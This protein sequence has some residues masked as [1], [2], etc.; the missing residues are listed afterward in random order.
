MKTYR[1]IFKKMSSMLLPAIAIRCFLFFTLFT[2]FS[3]IPSQAYSAGQWHI[4]TVDATSVSGGFGVS[5]ALDSSSRPHI[6]YMDHY[7]GGIKQNLRYA[8]WNGTSWDIQVVENCNIYSA[9]STS[10]VIDGLDNP[11]ISYVYAVDPV[12]CIF[13][14][15][16]ASWNGSWNIQTADPVLGSDIPYVSL[17][18][19]G[20]GNPCIAYVVRDGA[21]YLL[22]YAS[23]EE[24]SWNI[25]T[26]EATSYFTALSLDG[27]GNPHIAYMLWDGAKYLL[28][29]ASWEE[30]SWNIQT[31]EANLGNKGSYCSIKLDSSDNPHI[32]YVD[33]T[34]NTLKHASWNGTGWDIQLVAPSQG[35]STSLALDSNGH[36]YISYTYS[37]GDHLRCAAWNGT[38]WESQIV[39]TAESVGYYSSLAIDGNGNPHIAYSDFYNDALK[40]ASWEAEPLGG[41]LGGIKVTIEAPSL[42]G[43]TLDA[44]TKYIISWEATSDNGFPPGGDYISIYFSSNEG[45]SWSTITTLEENDPGTSSGTYEW[46]VPYL[47]FNNKCLISIEATDTSL[48]KAYDISDNTFKIKIMLLTVYVS[49]TGSD[50]TGTGTSWGTAFQTLQKGLNTVLPGG[51]VLLTGGTYTGPGNYNVLWP[52]YTGITLQGAGLG[53]TIISAEALGR[54][55]KVGNAVQ[56][57]IESLTIRD[58]EVSDG[59]G[60]AIYLSPG[61]SLWL[62]NVRMSGNKV[63]SIEGHAGVIS[64]VGSNVYALNS[65]FIRNQSGRA[66]SPEHQSVYAHGGVGHKG[67]WEVN[68]CQFIYNYAFGNGGVFETLTSLKATN[69]SFYGNFAALPYGDGSCLHDV[70]NAELTGCVFYGNRSNHGGVVYSSG[71]NLVTN[72]AFVNNFADNGGGVSLGGQWAVM[73]STFYEN[74]STTGPVAEGGN[75]DITNCIFWRNTSATYPDIYGTFNCT[76]TLKYCDVE[77]LDYII[78]PHFPPLHFP[79]NEGFSIKQDPLFLA[80]TAPYDIQLNNL[81]PCMNSGT[82][83]GA[84]PTDITGNSRPLPSINPDQNFDMGCYEQPS[85][86][87]INVLG[88]PAV[89]VLDPSD[90]GITLEA[91]SKYIITWT[92]T[93]DYL[94]FP[95]NDYISIYFSS[96]GGGTWTPVTALQEN[97]PAG[98][99]GTF[100][101][102]V[103]DLTSASCYISV[104]AKDI[105]GNIGSDISNNSFTIYQPARVIYPNGNE[106]FVIGSTNPVTWEIHGIPDGNVNIRLSRDGGS[107]WPEVIYSG[108]ALTGVS[109]YAWPTTGPASDECLISVEAKVSGVWYY[110]S[111][112]SVFK[113]IYPLAVT[114]EAPNGNE[115][116]YVGYPYNIQWKVTPEAE[117]IY[118]RLSTNEGTTWDTIITHETWTHTGVCTFSWI[119]TTDLVSTECLISVEASLNGV[120][121]NDRSNLTFSIAIP[122]FNVYINDTGSDE[123]GSGTHLNPYRTVTKGLV[124][125]DPG[126]VVWVMPGSYNEPLDYNV[127]WPNKNNVALKLT[128]EANGTTGPAT[129]DANYMGRIMTVPNAVNLT[130][131]GLTLQKGKPASG[132]NGGAINVTSYGATLLLK[133]D[134]IQYCTVES[135]CYGGAVY[136]P[137]DSTTIYASGTTFRNNNAYI[138]GVLYSGT[139]NAI[140]CAFISNGAAYGSVA[141][142][143]IWSDI[144]NCIFVSNNPFNKSFGSVAYGGTW[145]VYDSIFT[146]NNQGVANSSYFTVTN[147]T[148]ESNPGGVSN[149]GVW[150]VNNCSFIGNG[151][152]ASSPTW[153]VSD[154]IF[155]NN[156]KTS[157][158]GGVFSGVNTVIATNC[159]FYNNSASSNNGGVAS[160][161]HMTADN[162]I[163]AYNNAFQGG[164]YSGGASNWNVRNCVFAYNSA[165]SSTGV[166]NGA[167]WRSVNSIYWGNYAPTDPVFQT[168]NGGSTFKY[169]DIQSYSP[170]WPAG[171]GNISVE[172]LFISTAET[173]FQILPTSECVNTGTFEGAPQYDKLGVIRPQ[174]QTDPF[175]NFDMG[176]YEQVGSGIPMLTVI[177]PNGGESLTA[178]ASYPVKWNIAGS[179]NSDVF[180]RLSRDGGLTWDTLITQEPGVLGTTTY[181]WIPSISLASNNCLISIEAG[182]PNGWNFDTSNAIFGIYSPDAISPVV[183]IDAPTL[184]IMIGGNR[185][186]PIVWRA[187]DNVTIA[188]NATIIDLSLNNGATWSNIATGVNA[189]PYNWMVNG[190]NTSEAKVR[191]TVRDPSGNQAVATSDAFIIDSTPPA[192][193]V[194]SPTGVSVLTGGS[195]Y[196]VTWDATDNYGLASNSTTIE[197]SSNNGLTW[198][199]VASGLDSSPYSWTVNNVDTTAARIRVCA[200]DIAGNLGVGTSAAFTITSSLPPSTGTITIEVTVNGRRFLD[201]DIVPPN[202]P[203]DIRVRVTAIYTVSSVEVLVDGTKIQLIG[204]MGLPPEW[205]SVFTIIPHPWQQQHFLTISV[206]DIYG[207]SNIVTL[208]T[209][210]LAGGVQVVGM[211]MSFPNLFKPLSG[212]TALIQYT[213]SDDAPVVVIMYDITGQEVKRWE[214]TPGGN[215]GKAGINQIEWDGRSM[216]GEVVGNG[217]YVYKIISGNRTIATSK[218]VVLD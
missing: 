214:F 85:P 46:T 123:S 196:L 30:T 131:E 93:P 59:D 192:V 153:Y 53:F 164:V 57:F 167:I 62:E 212:G 102:T 60:G 186:Y 83:L 9:S 12:A 213:L 173:G 35:V 65:Q 28:K 101:W 150:K 64:S 87:M 217:M 39:D 92:A 216:F 105:Y 107:T 82:Y 20:S 159:A 71:T 21:K 42:P 70:A 16:Y 48:Y 194:L 6:S 133:N 13:T 156:V 89:V 197:F 151:G 161:T 43:I 108:T 198:G 179:V 69:C 178:E 191:V 142:S 183:T 143:G 152:V 90:A 129:I 162:C 55:I 97:D 154:S 15:R 103:P 158:N 207:N 58:G 63:V 31:V 113:I 41:S 11:H 138:G 215:G 94:G 188:A 204:P 175:R 120:W 75:W 155:R 34:M 98:N 172:P 50:I 17:K 45:A 77:D 3:L 109:T 160:G 124:Q 193:N 122:A 195:S 132:Q 168:L 33:S 218:L 135:S 190:V 106:N 80:T 189:S 184:G 208:E 66:W 117:E 147:S 49:V 24:T 128:F 73:N 52:A 37:I 81:S 114:V 14:L 86:I 22:K 209:K 127:T 88:W 5:L 47:E 95:D 165:S 29:Y 110:D 210:V 2:L 136:S 180:V 185:T 68:N 8:S 202:K 166:A 79:T 56:L 36:P 134:I 27:S 118:V 19:D 130:I 126:G 149:S 67:V 40:Y 141:Y 112:D 181:N 171:T 174:P 51:S 100:E 96:N 10:L 146:G 125:V 182:G 61:S 169:S 25:Q 23:W 211:P 104:R 91:A 26:V 4:E 203:N 84:P 44:G 72:C 139:C 76:G 163:F 119:P 187:T 115:K 99:T 157:G 7:Y 145:T 18:L 1:D 148:F 137:D 201:G 200:K 176:V 74:H 140:N 121:I 177:Q 111:S 205:W 78:P 116:I 144:R 54:A 32:S 170:G 199:N 206:R 38:T